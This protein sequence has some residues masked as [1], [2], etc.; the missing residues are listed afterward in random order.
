MISL[1]AFMEAFPVAFAAALIFILA[2]LCASPVRSDDLAVVHAY[3]DYQRPQIKPSVRQIASD[4][5]LPI[6]EISEQYGVD[7]LLT[8]I[9][10]FYES[11]FQP[12]L[13]GLRGEY[14]LMQVMLMRSGDILEQLRRGV[15]H[16][17]KSITVCGDML[18]GINHY[19][20]GHCKPVYKRPRARHEHY[21][22]AIEQFKSAVKSTEPAPALAPERLAENG[23]H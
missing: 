8:A 18:H 23:N 17:A 15:E 4:M 6:A 19:M 10:V 13:R 21:I 7:P 16:L 20:A 22:W 12:G 14:G 11:R 1:R 9:T 3:I 2:F 5:A